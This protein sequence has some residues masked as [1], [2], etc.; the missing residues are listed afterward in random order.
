[1]KIVKILGGL[2]NQM[3]QYAFALELDHR[4]GEPVYLDLSGYDDYGVHNGFELDRVFGIQPRLAS[5]KDIGRLATIP[6]GIWSRFRRKYLTKATHFIDRYFGYYPGV[7]DLPGD[8]YFDG[9]WQSEKYFSG[10][11]DQVRRAFVFKGDMGAK[12]NIFLAS[13][14]RPALAVHV[15]RGDYLA[16]E[17]LNVCGAAYYQ[18]ALAMALEQTAAKSIVVFSDDLQ[19]CRNTLSLDPDRTF[20]VDWNIGAY[21]WRDMALMAAC[22]HQVIANSSFSW[23]AAWL[24]NAPGRR[25]YAPEVWNMRQLRSNDPYYSFRFDDIVPGDWT[26][27]TTSHG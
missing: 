25:V 13:L 1:M 22:D 27:V 7:F 20:Y 4:T 3:F 11:R 21:S 5:A 14:A 18:A 16:S 26:R 24:N 19:W 10:A 6:K 12:N 15:R 2:G 9:Y 8:R 23:W 17:N